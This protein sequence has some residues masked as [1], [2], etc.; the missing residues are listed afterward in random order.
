[1]RRMRR[2]AAV[3]AALVYLCSDCVA[4]HA[5]Y[6]S[7]LSLLS[8][9]VS[10]RGDDLALST[11]DVDAFDPLTLECPEL[12]TCTMRIEF[13]AQLLKLDTAAEALISIS[14]RTLHILP[15]NPIT[16]VSGLGDGLSIATF[17]VWRRSL[18]PGTYSVRVKFRLVP[19][20][21]G[22]EAGGTSLRTLTV[23]MFTQ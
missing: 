10:S 1:M 12:A 6:S 22:G 18:M 4:V 11:A 3:T 21:G 23:Q 16:M 17:T 20:P 13:S 15:A 5:T 7:S 9:K 8:T 14:N 2:W 19:L